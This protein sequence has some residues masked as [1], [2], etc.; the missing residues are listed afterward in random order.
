VERV[1]QDDLPSISISRFRA[2]GVITPETTEVVVKFGDV[3][4][5]VGVK[6][7]KFPNGGGWSSFVCPCCSVQVRVLRLLDGSLICCCCCQRRGVRPRSSPM[8]VRQ[9][10]EH[11]VPKLKAM[12]LSETSLRLKP[13][14]WGKMER[15]KRHEATLA[16][17]EH[18]VAKAR[19]KQR[20]ND[21]AVHPE[22]A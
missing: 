4:R 7:R 11:R 12:L 8:S 22:D 20:V 5:T 1:F 15:R 3:E 6:A 16:R 14:L 21:D 18:I 17:C 19:F 10:A 2:T 13:H 9:R